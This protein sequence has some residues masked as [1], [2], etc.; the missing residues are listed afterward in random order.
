MPKFFVNKNQIQDGYITL[1]GE[2]AHHIS[3]SLRMAVGE[4]I[5]V[6]DMEGYDYACVLDTFTDTTVTAHIIEKYTSSTEPEI[7]IHLYQALPKGDKLDFIIQKSVECGAFDITPFESENCVVKIKNDAESKKI[8]RRNKISLE[9]AKQ[10]GRGIIPKVNTSISFNSMLENASKSDVVLFCY[11]GEGTLPMA[12]ALK[13]LRAERELKDISIIIGSEGGFSIAEADRAK[14]RG[15]I[16]IGLG[17]RI[18]RAET[19]AIMALSCLV[20]EFELA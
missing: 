7:R 11:E 3:R 18:L 15:F 6:S 20:Y 4:R 14:E 5:T 9:A 2:N 12:S 16:K 10:C 8:E 19:A 1:I 13:K 17:K